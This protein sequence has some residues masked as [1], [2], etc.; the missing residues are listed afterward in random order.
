MS[1][2]EHGRERQGGKGELVPP[3]LKTHRLGKEK[4][5]KKKISK[6]SRLCV[7]FFF[8][9]TGAEQPE[10]TALNSSLFV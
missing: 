1:D 4:N 6:S 2:S 7:I 5:L 8:L 10:K 9:E 3:S